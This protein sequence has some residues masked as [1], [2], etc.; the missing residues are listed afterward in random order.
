MSA[1]DA[2]RRGLRRL[3]EDREAAWRL[4]GIGVTLAIFFGLLSAFYL[5]DD[6]LFPNSDFE[7][8]SL[9]NWIPAEKAFLNQ[10]TFGDNSYYRNRGSSHLVG[11][12]Y[13]ASFENRPTEY[14]AKGSAQG[15]EP[16]G[17]LVSVPFKIRR[18]HIT[19]LL[20]GG[21]DSQREVVM[22]LV[23][24]RVMLVAKGQG[25]YTGGERMIRVDWDVSR[26]KGADAQII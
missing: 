9:Q 26:W 21:D 14:Q 1:G 17:R 16:V 2:L 11:N 22:L 4:V 6:L 23:D 12:Y 5:P 19:F 8:G 15:E 24:G 7:N 10:P 13:A 18:R 3:A 25:I 20:G